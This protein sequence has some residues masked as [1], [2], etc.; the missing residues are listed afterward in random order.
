MGSSVFGVILILDVPASS[1]ACAIRKAGSK[2]P[3]SRKR[4]QYFFIYSF[5]IYQ[6]F[7]ASSHLPVSLFHFPCIRIIPGILR[8]AEMQQRNAR[9]CQGSQAV[10][11]RAFCP[12]T[13]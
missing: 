12:E 9:L 7:Y 11:Q 5:F 8:I 3:M 10:D 13:A 4:M 6:Y 2:S 1:C